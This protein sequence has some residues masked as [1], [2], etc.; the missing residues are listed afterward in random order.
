M[1]TA[2]SSANVCGDRVVLETS[3]ESSSYNVTEPVCG[4]YCVL[5]VDHPG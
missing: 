1:L 4:H 5:C 3:K 2:L